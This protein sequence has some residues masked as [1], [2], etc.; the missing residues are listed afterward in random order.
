[1]AI[2]PNMWLVVA[3]LGSALGGTTTKLASSAISPILFAC[4]TFFVGA[5]FNIAA[6]FLMARDHGQ[7]LTSALR[8]NFVA[9]GALT[10]AVACA[11]LSNEVNYFMALKTGHDLSLVGPFSAAMTII[12]SLI[13]ARLLFKETITTQQIAG[14]G[15]AII[16]AALLY[17]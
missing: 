7:S 3:I 13:A 14:I 10:L 17:V 15:L 12:F 9:S 11:V 2:H 16:G 6:F 5:V 1:M 8:A 4:I